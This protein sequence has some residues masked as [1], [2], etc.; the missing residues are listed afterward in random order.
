MEISDLIEQVPGFPGKG[1]N[2]AKTKTKT[3]ANG[4]GEGKGAPERLNV[5]YLTKRCT[6]MNR[7]W[8]WQDAGVVRVWYREIREIR[9]ICHPRLFRVLGSNMTPGGVYR[10]CIE[11]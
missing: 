5:R 9:E 1:E 10:A 7:Y 2:P 6:G 3:W 8:E 11:L 4:P